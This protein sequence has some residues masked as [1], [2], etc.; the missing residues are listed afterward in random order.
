MAIPPLRRRLIH[1]P[2]VIEVVLGFS[3]IGTHQARARAR[4]DRTVPTGTSS[5]T[6]TSS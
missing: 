5:A 4:R 2:M 1:Q 3:E 6:A